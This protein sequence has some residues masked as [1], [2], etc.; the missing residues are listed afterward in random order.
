MYKK[1][2]FLM[3]GLFLLTAIF[4]FCTKIDYAK[5][6]SEAITISSISTAIYSALVSSLVNSELKNKMKKVDKTITW[7]TQL[8]VLAAYLKTAILFS[9]LNIVFSCAVLLFEER[10]CRCIAYRILETL[11]VATL[12]V[13]LMFTSMM[14]TFVVNRQVWDD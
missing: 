13:V 7:K 10:Y 9:M 3:I 4:T 8:G 14:C 11:G 1:H 2:K 12:A 5:I 6:G